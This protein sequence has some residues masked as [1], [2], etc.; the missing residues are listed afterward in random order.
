MNWRRLLLPTALILAL[1]L[2]AGVAQNIN[3]A[4][5]LSQDASGAFGVD[6]NSNV[7]WPGHFLTQATAP[8]MTLCGTSPTISGSDS[9]GTIVVGTT[10]LVCTLTFRQAFL[11]AP[12][13]VVSTPGTS[14]TP[15]TYVTGTTTIHFA[16]TGT[17]SSLRINYFCP[18]TT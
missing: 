13:C 10:A 5:Q 14:V 15:F 16:F 12:F 3:R 2:S 7:Y 11:A 6:T 8:A 1:G 18:G 4:L 9:W 17:L